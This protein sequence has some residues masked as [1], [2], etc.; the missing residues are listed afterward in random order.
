MIRSSRQDRSG[1]NSA[2]VQT[3][4]GGSRQQE[5]LNRWCA[6]AQVHLQTA[7]KWN[8]VGWRFLFS[9]QIQLATCRAA[10]QRPEPD[11]R[12]EIQ[13][14]QKLN[15]QPHSFTPGDI[16]RVTSFGLIAKKMVLH[17]SRVKP[18]KKRL[19]KNFLWAMQERVICRRIR[20]KEA[21]RCGPPRLDALTC[22]QVRP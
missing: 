5:R 10:T 21:A 9:R 6:L 7:L 18:A 8:E 16:D 14:S 1:Q 15:S 13:G 19:S 4:S 3:G 11:K 12:N 22:G 2:N 17:N 20:V